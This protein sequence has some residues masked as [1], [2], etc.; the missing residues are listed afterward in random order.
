VKEKLC[1]LY[2]PGFYRKLGPVLRERFGERVQKVTLRGGFGCPNRDGRIGKNG[3]I[4]CSEYALLP[5]SGPIYGPIEEQLAYG[6][7]IMAKRTNARLAIAYFQDGTATYASIDR[8]S[9]L[10]KKAITHPQVVALSVGTRPDCLGREVVELM[11]KLAQSKPVWVELGLQTADDDILKAMH[12][13]HTVA[14]F[15]D[16]TKRAHAYG[17]EVIAHVILDLPGET[18]AHRQATATCL[19]QLHV[20]GVK[21]HNLHVL[22][23]TELARMYKQGNVHL[24]TLPDYA[25][26]VADFLQQLDERIVIHRVSGQGPPELMIAPAWGRDK[27]RIFAEIDRALKNAHACQVKKKTRFFSR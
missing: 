5:N 23:G 24:A 3:C 25:T 12:R 8:L 2:S 22:R 1:M 4:F 6:L 14:D 11:A 16:S 18:K 19:N 21:I 10:Y 27:H 20:E 9:E 17:L 7:E 13:G 15:V 26:M